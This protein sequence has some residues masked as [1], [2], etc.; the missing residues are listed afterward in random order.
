M[1]PSMFGTWAEKVD[2]KPEGTLDLALMKSDLKGLS[3]L[4]QDTKNPAAAWLCWYLAQKW[5]IRAPR[6]VADAINQFAEK[7]AQ[8]AIEALDGNGETLIN[9]DVAGALWDTS[10]KEAKDGSRRG[11]TPLAEQLLLSERDPSLAL[12]VHELRKSGTED[13]AVEKAVKEIN[14]IEE[15]KKTS[16]KG[17]RTKSKKAKSKKAENKTAMN[18]RLKIKEDDN[19]GV[20]GFENAKRIAKAHRNDFIDAEVEARAE[21]S[22]ALN[23]YIRKKKRRVT[24][25]TT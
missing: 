18:R 12:R 1:A 21:A 14:E 5:K 15:D 19:E 9:A 20:L 3:T 13:E 6:P 2:L 11:V 25:R 7:I 10:P 16:A 8:L 23:A 24:R 4:F 22:R 17:K